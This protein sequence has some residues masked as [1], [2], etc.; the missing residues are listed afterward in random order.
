MPK[1]RAPSWN[2]PQLELWE[3]EANDVPLRRIE[4]HGTTTL[5]EERSDAKPSKAAKSEASTK[6]SDATDQNKRRKKKPRGRQTREKNSV[7]EMT[8]APKRRRSKGGP[9]GSPAAAP[10]PSRV[11]KPNR[12]VATTD[13]HARAHPRAHTGLT[14]RAEYYRPL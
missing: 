8:R 1:G 4:R 13:R 5:H 12:D 6:R 7:I 9:K 2:E 11:R 10:N 14:S 3:W